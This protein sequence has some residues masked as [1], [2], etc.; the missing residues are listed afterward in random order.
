MPTGERTPEPPSA[1][2]EEPE[3]VVFTP[4]N[5]LRLWIA[6]DSLVIT[7]GYAIYRAFGQNE[8]VQK[9]GDV[10]GRVATGLT[11]PDVFNWFSHV[12]ER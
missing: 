11:R 7:P 9:L 6:G 10:D 4:R 12:S 5:K 2:E 1:A 3:R 8:A